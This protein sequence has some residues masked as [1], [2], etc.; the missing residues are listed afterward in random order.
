[1][2]NE[3]INKYQSIMHLMPLITL[4]F[5]VVT[6]SLGHFIGHRSAIKRDNRKEYNTLVTPIRVSLLK[7][8][9]SIKNNNYQSVD[10]SHDDIIKISEMMSPRKSKALLATYSKYKDATSWD[11]LQCTT[12]N[13]GRIKVGDTGNAFKMAEELRKSLPR[14]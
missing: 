11:G 13:G 3:F 2:A 9:E 1:M 5:G 8:I 6:F 14:R 7:Q 10:I 4:A 12:T